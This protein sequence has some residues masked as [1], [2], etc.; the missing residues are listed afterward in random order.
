M[1]FS[2]GTRFG[3]YQIQSV[4]GAGGMGV[5]YRARD[6][7]LNRE[8][9]LKALPNRVA[10]D[11][12]RLARFR[13]EAQLLAALNHPHIAA[14]YELEEVDGVC[15]LILELVE[16]PTLAER[17]ARAPMA[18][19]DA[20]PIA[21]QIAEA[22]DAAH[23]KGIVHRDL[24][25]AN[26]KVRADG[27]VKVL[28]F[29][30]AKAVGG[31]G[32]DVSLSQGPTVTAGTREGVILGTVAYMSPE[33]AR[34][35]LVDKRTD[36]WAFGCVLYEMLVGRSPFAGETM[37]DTIAAVLERS[38]DWDALPAS[39][40]DHV[41]RLLLRT[42]E[43]DPTRRLRDI[44]E[45]RV[46]LDETLRPF[47]A[48]PSGVPRR[49]TLLRS[50]PV[51][52][53]AFVALI[54]LAGG[55][56]DRVR[57]RLPSVTSQ[58]AIGSLAVL[59]FAN[60]SADP[61]MEY[62]ADGITD[63][64]IDQLS[65]IPALKVTS[66]R[67]VFLYK[68]RD[69]DA[70]EIGRQLGVEA[71]LTGR[72]SARGDAFT[73]TLELID[74]K[75]NSHIWGERYE[76]KIAELSSVH[77][78][79]PVD[80]SKKLRVRLGGEARD[81]LS[82]QPTTSAEA[83][84]L[85]LQGRFAWERWTQ[86]G[87]TAAVSYF[88]EAIAKD[89]NYALAYSGLADAYLFGAGTGA[90]AKEAN[91]KAREAVAK[92]LVLDPA[93]GEAHASLGQL[94]MNDDW[95]FVAAEREF[96]RAIELSPS[97]VEAHHMYSH[98]LL[99][100]GRFEESR[101]ESDKVMGLDPLSS[102]GLGHL[103]YH[104]LSAGQYDDAISS[105]QAYLSKE[106][107]DVASYGQLG[108]AYYQKGLMRQ[109]FEA[110]QTSLT[111]NKMAPESLVA[112]RRAFSERGMDGFLRERIAQLKG[113]QR[114]EPGLTTS[115]EIARAYA[116]LGDRNAAFEW[117]QEAYTDHGGALVHLREDP[118]FNN[119]RVDPRFADLLRRIGLPPPTQVTG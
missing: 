67:A 15:A 107:G 28:D 52:A 51:L 89:P 10:A 61:D 68:G 45:A 113:T 111:L 65:Q 29:G 36:I 18:L 94:L 40:P 31:D 110:F 47:V 5:V 19:D 57:T 37:S 4:L 23:E 97:Y 101:V 62:Q 112:L 109:A 90:P 55:S 84:K 50:W 96:K 43:K 38:P 66:H 104:Y 24:K 42:L 48:P 25:P 108:D 100:M 9:A 98:Y 91:R 27:T 88:E 60:V 7:K 105:Y 63:R 76:G 81:R 119:L 17:I 11:S 49:R 35:K 102:L 70:K 2:A 30:L 95:D 83:Y 92:A 21:R 99:A 20:L 82:R 3:P 72:V 16:G 6:T 53:V 56:I 59:P 34:G 14:I 69:V 103:A 44:G 86:E 78:E 58:P 46:G 75:D 118:A 93:V 106:T 22:L 74:A 71:V 33:Q 1:T 117:L 32:P 87:S 12:E 26:I 80:I 13:R 73:I 85:Y 77:A 115:F 64:I 39:T 79:I 114:A 41:R 54:V 116:R 8:V